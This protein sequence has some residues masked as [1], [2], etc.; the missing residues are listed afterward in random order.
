LNRLTPYDLAVNERIEHRF[1]GISEEARL[2][3]KDATDP[4]QFVSIAT[5]QQILSDFESPE[6]LTDHPEAAADY[7]LL[8]YSAFRFWDGGKVVYQVTREG[9]NDDR[10]VAVTQE[11][12]RSTTDACYLQFTERW[13]WAQIGEGA[14]HEPLDGIF[15]A[16]SEDCRQLTLVAVMGMRVDRGGFSQ[17]SLTVAIEDLTAARH[18]V[19]FPL[20]EPLME[21]GREAGFRSIGSTAD[22]LLLTQ[23]ALDQVS[24]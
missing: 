22:L 9:W 1:P 18:E 12:A 15:L 7:L 5:V 11:P 23:L 4:A 24:S 2:A 17:V 8:L 19:E 16:P 13:F 21:G 6:V 10:N 3:K 14:P 20:F